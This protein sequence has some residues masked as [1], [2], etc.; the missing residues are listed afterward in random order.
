MWTGSEII[1]LKHYPNISID[2]N[3]LQGKKMEELLGGMLSN[4]AVF[5]G[6]IN[7]GMA[8]HNLTKPRF[9]SFVV[10]MSW[11]KVKGHLKTG[12]VKS[13]SSIGKWMCHNDETYKKYID[14]AV[15]YILGPCLIP[16]QSPPPPNSSVDL[17]RIWYQSIC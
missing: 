9:H 5:L 11:T 17:T 12:P 10:S 3:L 14:L 7:S 6:F 4:E 16:A 2:P 13:I 8:G 15:S 1:I